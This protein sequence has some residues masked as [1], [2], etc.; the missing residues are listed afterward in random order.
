MNAIN[1]ID[2]YKADHRRQ[3]PH[4]TTRVY[5]NWTPRSSRVDGDA[6]VVY[7]GGQYLRKKFLE[8]A[9]NDGFFSEP[10]S[11]VC[12]KYERQMM[13]CLGPNTIGTDHIRALHK[14]GHLPIE[15]REIPEGTA[16]PLR[17][18]MF[19]IE[20][21]HPDFAWITN[22]LETLMSCVLWQ[23]CTSATT[24]R[25]YRRILEGAAE[26][27]GS[28]LGFVDWQ[29]HDFSFRGMAGPEAAAIS[30]AAHLLFFTGTDTLPAIDLIEEY[31]GGSSEGFFIGGSVAATEHSVMCAGGEESE[32]A[33]FSRILDLY[34]R[35]I[36]SVVS[37]TWDL[38]GVL[39][40][41][42]PALKDRIMGRDGKTVIR[43]D[44]GD[45]ADILCGDPSVPAGSPASKGVIQL[46]WDVF[47]GTTTATG[48]KLLDSHIG[49]I[50]GDAITR[51]RATEITERLAANGFASANVVFGV[52]SFTYQHVTRDTYGFALKATW[53]EIDGKG[54]A[55]YKTPKTDNGVKNSARGRLAVTRD[56]SGKLA[57]IENATYEQERDS[58][59]RPTWV[60]GKSIVDESFE[61]IRTRARAALVQ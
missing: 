37:D 58:L 18:P 20:N 60:N 16:V 23:P 36:V 12:R 11:V 27:T 7:F 38:F 3:Y 9:F 19:T 45:P 5:S 41:I 54:R 39:T 50:Y 2:L 32:L 25:A 40:K 8:D 52:G 46:L 14:L 28:P 55:I 34:P 43:P 61:M 48:H 6:S 15:I 42:L 24:A 59:L 35:G 49:A 22:Y 30:G 31:Y 21:T 47:G 33:T 56:S 10:S 4:A 29:A 17:V 51:E 1:L 13:A 26:A 44:S 53:V 57:L